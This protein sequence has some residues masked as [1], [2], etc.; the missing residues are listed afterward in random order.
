MQAQST[1]GDRGGSIA[2]IGSTIVVIGVLAYF[3]EIASVDVASWLGGSGWTLFIIIPGLA[4][5][6][7]AAFLKDG[8]ALTATI[9]GAVVTTVGALL[10]YQDQ[11]AHYESWAYAWALIP[12]SV[13]AALAV[14]GL[15]FQRSDLVTVG[16]RMVAGFGVLLL[17]GAWFF[18]TIFRTNQAPFD[19]GDNW[20]IA[21]IALGGVLFIAGLLRGSAGRGSDEAS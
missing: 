21:L 15:R 14:H 13:G 18:E 3:L 6:V 5:L 11:T 7:A 8:A 1:R 10:L 17:V 4:L 16:T 19:L 2:A 12:G 9:A 20:P